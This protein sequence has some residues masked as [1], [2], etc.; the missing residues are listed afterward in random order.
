MLD[1]HGIRTLFGEKHLH[2]DNP[3]VIVRVD[4]VVCIVHARL[5]LEQRNLLV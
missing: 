2:I 4:G 1:G 3:V 5:G